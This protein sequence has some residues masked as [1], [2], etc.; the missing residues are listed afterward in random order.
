MLDGQL[1][2]LQ[3][4]DSPVSPI[5]TILPLDETDLD[6][7]ENKYKSPVSIRWYKFISKE[8]YQFH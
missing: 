5:S 2:A 6:N 3:I 4:A 7:L 8:K 1:I